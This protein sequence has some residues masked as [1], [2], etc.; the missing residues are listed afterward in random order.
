MIDPRTRRAEWLRRTTSDGRRS[1][2]PYANY[3]AAAASMR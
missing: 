1:P 2:A 3:A